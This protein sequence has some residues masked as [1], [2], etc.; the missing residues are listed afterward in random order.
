MFASADDFSH[1]I[2]DDSAAASSL[3]QMIGS[4]ALSRHDNAGTTTLLT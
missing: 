3:G 1:M 2:D 4:G